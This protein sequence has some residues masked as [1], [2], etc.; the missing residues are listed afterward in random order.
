MPVLYSKEKGKLGTL[1]GSIINWSKQLTS[2]DPED[3]VLYETLPAGYLRCDG[4]VYQAEVFPELATILGTGV[5][6]RYK[7]PDTTLLDNQFQVP[8]LGAKSTRAS[9]SANLGDYQDT[10]LFNDANQEIT[11]AGVGLEVQ[12][13]IGSTFE[14]QYQ[15]NFFLPSQTLEITGQPGFV[16]AT[17]NYTEETDV[18]H[19]AFQPHAHFHDGKRSRIKA[20]NGN[21]F[22]LFGRN[23]NISKST[24]CIMPWANNTE[25]PLCQARATVPAA[26]G[27]VRTY[28]AGCFPFGGTQRRTYWGGCW[29]GCQFTETNQCLIPA[30]IPQRYGGD[31]FVGS[32]GTGGMS[33]AVAE[34]L[35]N[36]VDTSGG[37][38]ADYLPGGSIGQGTPGD[39]TGRILQFGCSSGASPGGGGL[40]IAGSQAGF[41]VWGGATQTSGGSAA[42]VAGDCGIITYNGTI[43]C[44][45]TNQCGIGPAYCR[46]NLGTNNY[47]QL[48]ANY[49]PSIVPEAE[50][51]PFDSQ[52]DNPVYPA[53]NNV[54]ADIQE[55]GND[56]THKHF[57]PF[58]QDPHNF[59][60]KTNPTFIPAG[61]ITSTIEINVNEE[62]KADG[63]I[64][65][66]LVQEF[67]IK[68]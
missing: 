54:I 31:G 39:A 63:Y 26:A 11:K 43:S 7:K 48:A 30:D 35:G 19:T 46:S 58:N 5:N 28:E 32:Q 68:Y 1:T 24:L 50:Q 51:V 16:R 65:P 8:D 22:G 17:G 41:A 64:Q 53:L 67:L 52:A 34:Y 49:A 37:S 36:T 13:N 44:R 20:G 14:V 38:A 9:N 66:F 25:Q 59:Q 42:G 6:C 10:Y 55:T 3:P 33:N 21:E 60:I 57:V 23:S 4:K 40:G 62:N 12:S 56:C 61:D 15:G 2:N 45:V 29:G 27:I 18:L 47:V